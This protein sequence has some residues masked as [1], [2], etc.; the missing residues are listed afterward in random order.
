L[1]KPFLTD[2][3]G[4]IIFQFVALVI[5]MI[6]SIEFLI[7][8]LLKKPFPGREDTLNGGRPSV[9]DSKIKQMIFG[10]GLS[11]LCMFIR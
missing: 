3:I 6:L 2:T 7:H 1:Y 8:F 9:L 4:G 5:Y 10:A 11:S